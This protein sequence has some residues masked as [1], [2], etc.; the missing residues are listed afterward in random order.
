MANILLHTLVFPPDGN[1]NAF[2]FGDIALELQ[3]HGHKVTVIS[4]TPHYSILQDALDKQPFTNGE[5][6]WYKKSNFHGIECYH[7][8]VPDEKGSMIQRLKTYIRFHRCALKL[9]KIIGSK[10][11][12]VI[13]Q[14]PPLSI[15]IISSLMAKTKKAKSVYIVQDLF[16]DGSI[17]QGKIKNKLIIKILRAVEKSVY[18]RN[19]VIVAISKGIKGHLKQRIPKNTLLRLIPN[20]VDTD[21]YYPMSKVNSLSLELKTNKKFVISYVGNIGNA[22]D[23]SPVLYCAKQLKSLDILFIIAGSGIKKDYYESQ[24]KREKLNNIKFIGYQKREVTPLINA[25]S[26]VSLVML[27]PHIKDYSFPSKIYTLM[28]M[29]KPIV[30]MCSSGCSATEFVSRTKSGW[31]VKNGHNE[32]FT[33]LIQKLYS[34][35]EI[36]NE[37]GS[38][39]LKTVEKRYTKEFVGKE[40]NELIKELCQKQIE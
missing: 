31:V 32:K 24:A 37:A 40:Y 8:V 4:T 16:P 27:A 14:S 35:P 30:L 19:D 29:A 1:S 28:G 7:I 3:K 6:D 11:D 21:I 34:N 36:L 15:G 20:F 2:I 9:S 22:Q 13:A 25:L 18:K 17:A 38:N 39:S 12:A 33:A 5:K 26:D 23:L 10:V